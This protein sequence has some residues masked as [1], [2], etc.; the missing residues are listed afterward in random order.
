MSHL[1]LLSFMEKYQHLSGTLLCLG[2][3][4][5]IGAAWALTMKRRSLGMGFSLLS[6]VVGAWL[7]LSFLMKYYTFSDK[8]ILNEVLSAAIGALILTVSLNLIFG[9]NRGKDRTAWRA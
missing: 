6:G 9:S 8:P 3:G 5:L 4:V 7:Y 1:Y 2:I